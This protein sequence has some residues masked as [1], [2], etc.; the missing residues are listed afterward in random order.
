MQVFGGR[1]EQRE[2]RILGHGNS[3]YGNM[4]VGCPWYTCSTRRTQYEDQ[5]YCKQWTEVVMVMLHLGGLIN[6][7]TGHT[8]AVHDNE[9]GHACMVV[10][11]FSLFL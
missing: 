8:L 7:Y 6:C 11:L 3:L 9:T 1:S 10:Y 2:Q 4:M 5:I